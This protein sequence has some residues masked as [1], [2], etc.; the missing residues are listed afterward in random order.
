MEFVL[1]IFISGLIAIVPDQ[2]LEEATLLFV[3]VPDGYTGHAGEPVEPTVEAS[4]KSKDF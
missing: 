4:E 2:A 3:D 1:R